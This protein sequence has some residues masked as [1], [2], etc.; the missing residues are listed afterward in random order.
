MKRFRSR[1]A[2]VIFGVAVSN[3]VK[4]EDVAVLTGANS[5]RLGGEFRAE[6]INDNRR[7]YKHEGYSPSQAST[8][9]VTN[10]YIL[11]SGYISPDTEYG[12]RFDLLNATNSPLEFG[13]GTH[14][15]TKSFGLSIG[16]ERV[17]QGGWHHLNQ[18]YRTHA[19]GLYARNLAFSDYAPAWGLHF[20]IQG[21][22]TLQL[23]NDVVQDPIDV[24]DKAVAN[25]W[26]KDQHPAWILAWLGDFG[27][28]KPLLIFGSYDNNRSRY[29]DFGLRTGL[30][31][32]NA[33]LDY[34]NDRLSY[35]IPVGS[36][37]SR[38]DQKETDVKTSYT[39]NLS[40]EFRNLVTPWV[41]YSYYDR[42]QANDPGAGLSDHQFNLSKVVESIPGGVGYTW[43]DNG[44]VWGLGVD[45]NL[46]G[47]NWNP[48]IAYTSTSGKFLK[49]PSGTEGEMRTNALVKVGVLGT[50]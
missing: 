8:F 32:I 23:V 25:R 7:L 34:H 13:Y 12:F 15:F 41:F 19:D 42:E 16:K 36:E 33:T 2:I 24:L 1:I 40:Y 48:F 31:G 4:A 46:L 6:F 27:L 35:R 20:K 9:E 29:V 43:D 11:L 38:V 28:V 30:N 18:G 49:E 5:A 26:N 45:V 17:L 14:W 10:A 50:I 47:K 21:L 3:V 22:V 44:A 39:V 37:E